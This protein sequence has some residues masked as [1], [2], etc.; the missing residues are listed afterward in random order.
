MLAVLALFS[1]TLATFAV[2]GYY[3]GR[4]PACHRPVI[5]TD[6]VAWSRGAAY[7]LDCTRYRLGNR[8]K[9]ALPWQR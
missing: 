6:T 1:R 8:G 9:E 7:H 2:D 4:C 5:S 3:R